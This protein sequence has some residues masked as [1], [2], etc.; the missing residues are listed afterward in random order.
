[1]SLIWPECV[2]FYKKVIMLIMSKSY[3]DYEEQLAWSM[4]WSV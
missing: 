4:T 3:D 1:M 2:S